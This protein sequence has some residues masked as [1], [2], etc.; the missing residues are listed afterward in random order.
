MLRISQ[1]W[2]ILESHMPRDTWVSINKI[3]E[4]VE[5]NVELEAED[6]TPAAPGATEP[7]WRRNVRNT[8]Q[9]RKTSGHLLWDN[10]GRYAL[11]TAATV[12]APITKNQHSD[13][14]NDSK[15][16][17][18][19]AVDIVLRRFNRPAHHSEI[20]Q[21]IVEAGLYDFGAQS[22]SD[23]VGRRMREHIAPHSTTPRYVKVAAA[24]YTLAETALP[25]EQRGRANRRNS[26]RWSN[27]ILTAQ[28]ELDLIL[29]RQR[30]RAEEQ[31]AF[32]PTNLWDARIRTVAAIVRRQGQAEFRNGLLAAYGRYCAVTG[33]DVEQALEAAHI[34]PYEGERS[35]DLTNG[36]LLR[37]DIHTLFDLGLLTIDD[38]YRV[39]LAHSLLNSSYNEL[40]GKPMRLPESDS[41][42]PSK[43]A[44]RARRELMG[45]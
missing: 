24:T 40:H 10:A 44:L 11:P 27:V 26:A 30:E 41:L 4:L 14:G 43:L 9:H 22:P 45:N 34:Y 20:Y 35:N 3:Y 1:I 28:E 18:L 38:Q 15:L 17:I 33:C 21:A 25:Q 8:L 42:H 16:T 31:G 2:A 13:A 32:D 7:K 12:E 6:Y 29:T 5:R 36:I 37:A 23:F 19:Q 39:E